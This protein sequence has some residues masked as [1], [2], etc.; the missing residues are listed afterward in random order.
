MQKTDDMPLWV[1]LAFSS[2]ETRRGALLLL[3]S[4]LAFTVYS[5]PWVLYFK[6][7]VWISTIFLIEDWSWVAMMAPITLWY[8]LSLRWVDRRSRWAKPQV[9]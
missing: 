1:F 7:I 4:C 8:W 3:W 9:N 5:I 6:D 2:I